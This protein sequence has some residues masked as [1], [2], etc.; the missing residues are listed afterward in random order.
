[1]TKEDSKLLYLSVLFSREGVAELDGMTEAVF[2]PRQDIQR[3]ELASGSGAERPALQA[4]AGLVLVLLGLLGAKAIWS[5]L[6]QGGVLSI[7]H[8]GMV[9]FAVLGVWLLWTGLRKRTFLLVTTQSD[10]RKLVF[11][12][13][14]DLGTLHEF[15]DKARRELGYT[16]DSRLPNVSSR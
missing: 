2:I 16:V 1:M 7:A 10:T 6:Q 4:I 13:E 15:L 8:V 11:H 3:M 5:W 14:I 9:A 12:G